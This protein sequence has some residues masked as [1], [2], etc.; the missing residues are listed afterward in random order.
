MGCS[1]CVEP[2]TELACKQCGQWATRKALEIHGPTV[3]Y[4]IAYSKMQEVLR[5]IPF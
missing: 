3:N 5:I 4:D 1:L 2:P